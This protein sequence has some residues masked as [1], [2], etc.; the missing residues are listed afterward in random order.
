[1][2]AEQSNEYKDPAT[3]HNPSASITLGLLE[4]SRIQMAGS[5]SNMAQ[6]SVSCPFLPDLFHPNRL[7]HFGGLGAL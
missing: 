6:G 2:P 1:M 4:L 5:Y 7:R 3:Q